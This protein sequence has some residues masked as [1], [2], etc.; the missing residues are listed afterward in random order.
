MVS[1]HLNRFV[2]PAILWALAP[3]LVAMAQEDDRP[4]PEPP[5][6]TGSS[7]EAAGEPTRFPGT[8]GSSSNES[9]KSNR[10]SDRIDPEEE[11]HLERRPIPDGKMNLALDEV[12]IS[13][14]IP[15]IAE[16]TGKIV[17]PLGLE[18]SG[19]GLGTGGGKIT[20]IVDEPIE[21][22]EALEMIFSALRMNKIAVIERPDVIILTKLEITQITNEMSDI[23]VLDSAIDVRDRL[24]RGT[25]VLKIFNVERTDAGDISEKLA[26][27]KPDYAEVWVDE[28]SNQI[29]VLGDIGLC[30]QYDKIIRELDQKWLNRKLH[31]F[32]LKWADANEVSANILDIFE[33]GTATTSA[34]SSSTNRSNTQQRGNSRTTSTTTASGV[35]LRLTVN[36]QQNAVTVQCE[37]EVM[38][39]IAML[40]LTEWDVP[41]SPGTSRLF[42]LKYTDPLKVKT[43]LEE[44]LGES[45]SSGT[46]ARGGQNAQRANATQAISGIYSIDAYPD[47]NALL[48]LAKTVESFDFI[49]TIIQ[50]IDQPSSVGVPRIVPLKYARAVELAEELNVLLSKPGANVSIPRPESGL[51]GE[52]FESPSGTTSGG[53][54]TDSSGSQD[55]SFP[56]QRG[57][58][59]DDQSP[60]S[61]LIGKVRIVPI[62]RQNAL[63]ILSP[64]SYIEPMVELIESFDI[65]R[66]QVLLSATIVEVDITDQWNLGAKWGNNPQAS[67]NVNG[68]FFGGGLF[69]AAAAGTAGA[70]GGFAFGITDFL[71]SLLDGTTSSTLN[72]SAFDVAVIIEALAQVTNTRIIQEPRVFTA[73]NE[74]AIFFSGREVPI[75]VSNTTDLSGGNSLNTQIEYRD[76]GVFLNVRPRITQEGTVD[77]EISLQL[78]DSVGSV[79]VGQISGEVFSRKQVNSHVIV[80]DGQTVVLGGLLKETETQIRQKIP[81]LGDIPILGELFKYN[82]ESLE[83]Q[84]L[85]AFITPTVVHRPLDNYENYNRDDLIRL[86]EVAQP[87][88]DQVVGRSWFSEGELQLNISERISASKNAEEARRRVEEEDVQLPD[89]MDQPE[90]DNIESTEPDDVPRDLDDID[91]LKPRKQPE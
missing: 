46:Q 89:Q 14:L 60:E 50:E 43:L 90:I 38:E 3:A 25:I 6:S 65:P 79:T 27:M 67:T 69:D 77:L 13:D 61:S 5:T 18:G 68:Q 52:G 75:P 28:M 7:E 80:L 16:V 35:E 34:R 88:A 49:Q 24:D 86:E 87:L 20:L 47:K 41:R 78:S 62:V 9:G 8:E 82:D 29:I 17:M 51:S 36:V 85:L 83:R 30:Q 59:S 84:E 21:K 37:P 22:R 91:N 63:A 19:I 72:V 64:A 33:E 23:P 45:T 39:E 71:D 44:V 53:S 4:A 26:D 10:P 66:R 81:L 76:V 56:W 15:W 31:T 1:R 32:R 2:F 11:A 40:I 73:D 55:L 12:S 74:E 42:V 57:S 54:S 58:E 48:V 70:A